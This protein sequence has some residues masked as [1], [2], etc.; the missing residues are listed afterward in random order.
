VADEL[1]TGKAYIGN[2][3]GLIEFEPRYFLGEFN[4]HDWNLLSGQPV[5]QSRFEMHTL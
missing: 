3:L 2:L 5:T 1:Q 4:E